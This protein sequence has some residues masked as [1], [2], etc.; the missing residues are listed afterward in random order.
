M[1][2]KF[3]DQKLKLG[4]KLVVVVVVVVVGWILLVVVRV[5]LFLLFFFFLKHSQL[6]P[7]LSTPGFVLGGCLFQTGANVG[8]AEPWM[9]QGDG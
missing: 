8:K 7:G 2:V 6:P 9:E 5:C 3:Y 4:R 1:K